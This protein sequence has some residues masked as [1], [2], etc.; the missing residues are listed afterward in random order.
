[1]IYCI[2]Y[3]CPECVTPCDT[4]PLQICTECVQAGSEEEAAEIFDNNKPCGR[5]KIIGVEA[6]LF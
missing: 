2:Y 5:M 3:N 4:D 6:I 1:M